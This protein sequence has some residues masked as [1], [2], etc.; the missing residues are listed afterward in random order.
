MATRD[1]FHKQME[2]WLDMPIE[3]MVN[4][5]TELDK[6]I[7]LSGKFAKNEEGDIT[8]T[9]GKHSGKSVQKIYSEDPEYF[10]W[11]YEKAEMP[12]DT[13]M[14]ARRVYAKLSE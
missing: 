6:K 7:D 10:R 14:I 3:E 11:M 4:A 1:I 13:K 12:T 9:F 8:L 5:T 2:E